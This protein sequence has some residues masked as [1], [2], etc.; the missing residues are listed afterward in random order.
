[1]RELIYNPHVA[2]GHNNQGKHVF[3]VIVVVQQGV[4]ILYRIKN[5]N[6]DPG[7]GIPSDSKY[8]IEFFFGNPSNPTQWHNITNLSPRLPF[9]IGGNRFEIAQFSRF[10]DNMVTAHFEVVIKGHP[11]IPFTEN[12][13]QNKEDM[14]ILIHGGA[15]HRPK[16]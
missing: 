1:M 2:V 6:D 4:D 13:D 3:S 10:I 7:S 12:F 5:T 14:S 16:P 15:I 8:A 11:A 9:S